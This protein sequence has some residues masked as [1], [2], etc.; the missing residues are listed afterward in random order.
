MVHLLLQLLVVLDPEL[1]QVASV[2]GLLIERLV[3]AGEVGYRAL[4]LAQFSS[5]LSLDECQ[6]IRVANQIGLVDENI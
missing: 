4:A 6:R 5:L 1:V 3:G 2:E